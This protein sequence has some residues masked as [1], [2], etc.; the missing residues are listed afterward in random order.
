MRNLIRV[1]ETIFYAA[2]SADGFLAGPDGDMTWAEKY[3]T[4]EEDYG[5]AELLG[6]CSAILM[7]RATFEFELEA[8]VSGARALPTYVLT[9]IPELYQQHAVQDLHFVGG[10]IAEVLTLIRAHH[11]GNVFVMG[12]SNVVEQ[13]VS[14]GLLDVVRL[15]RAPD[16]LGRGVPLFKDSDALTDFELDSTRSFSSGLIESVYRLK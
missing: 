7:G 5:F 8:G 3:L 13:L 16:M 12:G 14:R 11:P 6:Q 10:D 15:F 1:S 4:T 2:I 9:H